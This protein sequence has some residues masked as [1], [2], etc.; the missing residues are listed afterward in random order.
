MSSDLSFVANVLGILGVLGTFLSALYA[1]WQSYKTRRDAQ[2]E[3]QRQDQSITIVLRD[4]DSGQEYVLP[5]SLRREHLTRSEL[6]GYLGVAQKN[7][8]G[9]FNLDYL[10]TRPFFEQLEHAQEGRGPA[11]LTIPATGGE[12]EQFRIEPERG[13]PVPQDHEGASEDGVALQPRPS[14][15]PAAPVGT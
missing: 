4:R 11:S 7:H 5:V 8:K 14:G 12:I 9:R 3:R 15:S 6:M 2:R 1:G 13:K 10:A